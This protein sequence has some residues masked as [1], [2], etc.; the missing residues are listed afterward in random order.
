MNKMPFR[1]IL[2]VAGLG[3]M[4][5]LYGKIDFIQKQ[6][7]TFASERERKLLEGFFMRRLY[8]GVDR[9]DY[10]VNWSHAA[11]KRNVVLH[12]VGAADNDTGYV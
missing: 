4:N 2:E 8:V 5:A 12:A 6:C 9:Q 11:D 3:S 1:R 10:V 7:L